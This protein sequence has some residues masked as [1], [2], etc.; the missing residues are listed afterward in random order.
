LEGTFH[1]LDYGDCYRSPG[2]EILPR[3]VDGWGLGEREGDTGPAEKM[4]Y[5]RRSS[6]GIKKHK[7][8]MGR[9]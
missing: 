6:S 9:S 8:V 2:V 5:G 4:V 1:I 3:D 7:E